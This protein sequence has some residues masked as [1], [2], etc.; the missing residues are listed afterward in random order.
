[1]QSA[2]HEGAVG[3]GV[4]EALQAAGVAD[5]AA[6]YQLDRRERAADGADEREVHAGARPHA[7]EVEDDYT[8][9]P[10]LGGQLG[11]GQGGARS[12]RR[13][14]RERLTGAEVEGEDR[15]TGRGGRRASARSRT[16]DAGHELLDRGA[17]VGRDRQRFETDYYPGR[18]VVEH[19]ARLGRGG[20]AGINPAPH[21]AA[22]PGYRAAERA[23]R[24]ASHYRVEVG[25]V[26]LIQAELVVEGPGERE[27][28]TGATWRE[29][30]R[31]WRV[32]VPIPR[33]GV[34]RTTAEY[35]EYR[36]YSHWELRER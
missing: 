1:M 11:D 35:V 33:P 28:I 9:G 7:G 3:A 29:V 22:R 26:E 15:A 14:G 27:R 36:N 18:A 12:E 24:R 30:R 5:P 25:K 31:Q 16:F 34:D 32:T 4:G 8:P 13:M 23:L 21:S 19:F 17:R 2:A 20:D 6:G 10:R